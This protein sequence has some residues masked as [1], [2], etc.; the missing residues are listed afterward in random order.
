MNIERIKFMCLRFRRGEN[1]GTWFSAAL[2]RLPGD[3]LA[4][5]L[6]FP[7][8]SLY[9]RGAFLGKMDFLLHTLLPLVSLFGKAFSL[10]LAFSDSPSPCLCCFV[11]SSDVCQVLGPPVSMSSCFELHMRSHN[12]VCQQY[13][14]KVT[15]VFL[16]EGHCFVEWVQPQCFLLVWRSI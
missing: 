10:K 14:S 13:H 15:N 1:W 12:V 9:A 8:S 5:Y 4:A 2:E 7:L 16:N 11:Y 3:R 6:T